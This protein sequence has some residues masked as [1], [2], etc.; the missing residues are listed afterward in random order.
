MRVR[1]GLER[2]LIDPLED[3]LIPYADLAQPCRVHAL[4]PSEPWPGNSL[5][6]PGYCQHRGETHA[7]GPSLLGALLLCELIPVE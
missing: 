4:N 2:G 3:W 7:Q 1:P 6:C 5:A